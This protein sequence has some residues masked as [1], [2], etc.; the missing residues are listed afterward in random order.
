MERYK[1]GLDTYVISGN[2]VSNVFMIVPPILGAYL[3]YIDGLETRII[4]CHLALMGSNL[5]LC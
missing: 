3:A 5:H 1:Y 2:T 4:V